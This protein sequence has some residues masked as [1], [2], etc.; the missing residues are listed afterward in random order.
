[1]TTGVALLTVAAATAFDLTA[2]LQRAVPDYTAALQ[3]SFEAGTSASAILHRLIAA[4][5][6]TGI[7]SCGCRCPRR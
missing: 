7:R 4:P 6:P 1:M 3:K 5:E 2:G